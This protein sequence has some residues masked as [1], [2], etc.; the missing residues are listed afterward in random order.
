MLV[1]GANSTWSIGGNLSVGIWYN[2]TA[3]LDIT[4]GGSVSVGDE[5]YVGDLSGSTCAV[6]VDGTNS[7]WTVK[8]Y[9]YLGKDGSGSLNITS[10][11]QVINE[12]W[13]YVA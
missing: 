10:G 6:T 9:L 11:G 7:I 2:G 13:C 12:D 5:A 4:N 1:S 8:D 3:T